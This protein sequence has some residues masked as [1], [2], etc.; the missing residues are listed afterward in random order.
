MAVKMNTASI[1]NTRA[2]LVR[3]IMKL[4]SSLS[5]SNEIR[6]VISVG[7]VESHDRLEC[8]PIPQHYRS[9]E[10]LNLSREDC[11]TSILDI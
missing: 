3:V 7:K 6:V 8:V 5:E 1:I 2:T 11:T 4:F 10:P 9:T